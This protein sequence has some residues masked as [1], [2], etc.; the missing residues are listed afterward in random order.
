MTQNKENNNQKSN[1]AEP[2]SAQSSDVAKSEE[3]I[4]NFWQERRIFEKSLEKPSPKGEFVF[5][6]GPPF[7]TGLPHYGHIL[8]GT[9]KDCILRFK[10]MQG[11]HV[12]RR[13]GWD[14]HGLPIE[15]LVEKELSLRSKKD[16]EL[17]G[18]ERF[19]AV[20]KESVMRFADE[21]HKQ[22]PRLGRFV[23]ME[24]DYR[25][26]DSTFT[27]SVWWAFKTLYTKGLIYRGFKS[28]H[29]C[30]RCETTL[31]NFEVSQGYKDITDI[32]VYVRFPL[33]REP[34]TF[35]L[36]WTTTPWT[37]PGNVALAVNPDA[38]YLK[39]KIGP[40]RYVLAESRVAAL[41]EQ[42][43]VLETLPGR[44]LIG[45]AYKPLF[46]YYLGAKL[47]GM[48]NAF[49]VYGARFVTTDEGTGIVHI[50][51]AFGEDDYQLAKEKKLPF[52]QHVALSGV[53]KK[54]VRDFVGRR[55][56]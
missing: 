35:F 49:L 30:P 12:P 42:Y 52:I 36:V 43:E 45:E 41:K 1:P 3:E 13:W 54:E 8:A 17:Y 33:T 40:N 20:A 47:E 32:S 24:N 14:C 18:L 29:I 15:N 5:Y 16:I 23:D 4:L 10:T 28:M 25:T 48:E 39:V 34:G 22:I 51:P 7:A 44:K 55:N 11:Y 21:W 6:D 9:I 19:N 2:A 56:Y 53:F 38:K 27:E 50:A 37:L 31:S 26:M 46:D